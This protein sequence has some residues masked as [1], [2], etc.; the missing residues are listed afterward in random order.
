VR[1]AW[2]R[3]GHIFEA[4]GRRPSDATENWLSD[5]FKRFRG[6]LC[7]AV[8]IV[9]DSLGVILFIRYTDYPKQ[10]VVSACCLASAITAIVALRARTKPQSIRRTWWALALF[11][12]TIALMVLVDN[13]WP[14]L[15]PS[16]C[17]DSC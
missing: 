13:L 4:I 3:L 11:T 7:W 15:F 2:H 17:Y 12:V 5:P 6:Q 9:G 1:R 8:I 10:L 14:P 16:L